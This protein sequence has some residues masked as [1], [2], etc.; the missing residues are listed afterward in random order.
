M[1]GT[2]KI[3]NTDHVHRVLYGYIVSQACFNCDFIVYLSWTFD[4]TSNSGHII[5]VLSWHWA[6]NGNDEFSN[7][8]SNEAIVEPVLRFRIAAGSLMCDAVNICVRGAHSCCVCTRR[9]QRPQ[10]ADNLWSRRCPSAFSAM[11]SFEFTF[12]SLASDHEKSF[13]CYLWFYKSSSA[14]PLTPLFSGFLIIPPD[15][16]ELRRWN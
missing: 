4:S 8:V 15:K 12:C 6:T 16:D 1:K 14:L 7:N 10:C 2:L 5:F 9:G 3:S 11:S 13:F